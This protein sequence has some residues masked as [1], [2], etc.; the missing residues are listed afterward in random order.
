MRVADRADLAIRNIALGVRDNP[1]CN[2]ANTACGRHARAKQLTADNV[3]NR[4]VDLIC[5]SRAAPRFNTPAKSAPALKQCHRVHRKH[6]ADLAVRN[7]TVCHVRE[8]NRADR[9][10]GLNTCQRFAAGVDNGTNGCG[11]G[12]ASDGNLTIAKSNATYLSSSLNAWNLKTWNDVTCIKRRLN[13]SNCDFALRIRSTDLADSYVRLDALRVGNITDLA[14]CLNAGQL[15]LTVP[16]PQVANFSNQ[17]NTVQDLGGDHFALFNGG[18]NTG[19]VHDHVNSGNIPNF[20]RNLYT[21]EYLRGNKV[22]DLTNGFNAANL[23]LKL[24]ECLRDG[25]GSLNAS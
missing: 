1:G 21:I 23:D 24:G 10:R 6:I 15:D 22:S 2:R 18:L 16:D 14:R 11:G 25:A 20:A 5:P 7:L 17:L 19:Q 12:Y 9:A 8:L 4:C 13:P 3:S